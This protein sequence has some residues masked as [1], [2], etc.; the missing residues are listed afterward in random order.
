MEPL[1]LNVFCVFISQP[2]QTLNIYYRT[3]T[4]LTPDPGYTFQTKDIYYRINNG[5]W[6]V[7]GTA[8]SS[9]GP[10]GYATVASITVQV[11]D[12]VE[13]YFSDITTSYNY[14]YGN[15]GPFYGGGLS[16]STIINGTNNVYFNI[17]SQNYGLNSTFCQ[18]A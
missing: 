13:Y 4:V 12:L 17:C 11:N 1:Q 15:N 10:S 7:A 2:S 8:N 5:P 3:Q 18:I 16:S 6:V 14:N 9:Q